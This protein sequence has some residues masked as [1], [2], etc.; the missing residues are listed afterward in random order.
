KACRVGAGRGRARHVGLYVLVGI[1]IERPA[2]LGIEAARPVQ[3]VHILLAGNE[4]AVHAV[5]RV[6]EAVAGAVHDELA[7]LAIHLGVDDLVLGNLVVVIRVVRR[8]L[9][10]PLDLPVIGIHGEHTRGPLV[11]ARPVFGVVVGAS[12]A[13]ALEN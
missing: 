7:V 8:V 13:D 2:G 5:E 1:I 4:R 3:L 11:V 9:E 12:I 6:V 10:A